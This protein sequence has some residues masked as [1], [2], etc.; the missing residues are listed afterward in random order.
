MRLLTAKVGL[1]WWALY[2]FKFADNTDYVPLNELVDAESMQ[3]VTNIADHS[4]EPMEQGV[5]VVRQLLQYLQN[6]VNGFKQQQGQQQN[7]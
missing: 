4:V 7:P 2:G 1:D 6:F 3:Y 5:I